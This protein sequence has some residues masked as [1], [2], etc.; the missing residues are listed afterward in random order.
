MKETERTSQAVEVYM[1]LLLLCV[2]LFLASA[3]AKSAIGEMRGWWKRKIF[4]LEVEALPDGT[5]LVAWFDADANEDYIGRYDAAGSMRWSRRLAGRASSGRGEALAS[6]PGFAVARYTDSASLG[7]WVSVI[8]LDT[9]AQRWTTQ[10]RVFPLREYDEDGRSHAYAPMVVTATTVTVPVHEQAV[11]ELSRATGAVV[12]AHR[13]AF[14]LQSW[15][16]NG[17]LVEREMRGPAVTT[18]DA[19]GTLLSIQAATWGSAYDRGCEVVSRGKFRGSL[20]L[21]VNDDVTRSAHVFVTRNDGAIERRIRLPQRAFA[22]SGRWM[23]VAEEDPWETELPRFVPIETVG[24]ERRDR[25]VIVDLEQGSVT[26]TFDY[27]PFTQ[28]YRHGAHW[29]IVSDHRWTAIDGTTGAVSRAFLPNPAY[30]SEPS[31]AGGYL[32]TTAPARLRLERVSVERV[33]MATLAPTFGN[34]LV[35]RAPSS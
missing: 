13:R 5:A 17:E 28:T 16:K 4:T 9:G 24:S 25:G 34:G 30:G 11:L 35:R 12:R 23:I 15:V 2:A 3:M 27:D 22:P 7:E 10:V 19:N 8:D 18:R 26:K 32:W 20:V 21:V 14:V 6:G 29:V 1:K 31:A 33:E